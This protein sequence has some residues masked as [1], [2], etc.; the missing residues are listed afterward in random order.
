MVHPGHCDVTANHPGRNTLHTSLVSLAV[1]SPG[2]VLIPR[3]AECHVLLLAQPR[4]QLRHDALARDGPPHLVADIL[5]QHL[6]VEFAL[7]LYAQHPQGGR[8]VEVPRDPHVTEV[9]VECDAP[10]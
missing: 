9:H 2:P 7:R 3:Q 4:H 8:H 5:V 1:S 10:D 6:A